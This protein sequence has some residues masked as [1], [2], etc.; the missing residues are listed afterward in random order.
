MGMRRELRLYLALNVHVSGMDIYGQP[1]AQEATTID[2][3]GV[4]ARIKGITRALQRGCV[5]WLHCRGNKGRFGVRW[6]G[7]P[8]TASHGHVGLQFLDQGKFNWGRTI[9]KIPG[10]AFPS[11][12]T[13]RKSGSTYL[14]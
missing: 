9:P 1:F 2:V 13:D 3:T 12:E 10:D 6:I 4:G 7:K 5:I 14:R 11:H 8:G